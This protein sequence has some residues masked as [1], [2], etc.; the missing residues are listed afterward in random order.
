M[1]KRST[2]SMWRSQVPGG[3]GSESPNP[4]RSGATA[5]RPALA[6]AGSSSRHM[7]EDSG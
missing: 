7:Y 5:H 1:R 4:A 2:D 3:S 6:T